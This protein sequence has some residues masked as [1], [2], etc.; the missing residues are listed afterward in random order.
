MGLNEYLAVMP[1]F[2]AA[3]QQFRQQAGGAPLTDMNAALLQQAQQPEFDLMGALEQ[4]QAIP[5]PR[6]GFSENFAQALAGMQFGPP[7]NFG[8][9]LVQGLARGFSGA[10]NRRVASEEEKA[11]TRRAAASELAKARWERVN[12]EKD[13]ARNLLLSAADKEMNR[14]SR[15]DLQAQR[16]EAAWQRLMAQI[17]ASNDRLN[18]SLSARYGAT[19]QDQVEA[20]AMR[21][22]SGQVDGIEKVP[23]AGGMRNAVNAFMVS[24]GLDITPKKYREVMGTLS[25]AESVVESLASFVPKVNKGN[26]TQRAIQ[27]PGKAAAIAFQTDPD[28][29]QYNAEVNG[30][31]AILS[32]A[33]GERGVLTDQDVARAKKLV[34][35]PYDTQK[36]AEGKIRGLREFFKEQKM[37]ANKA[38]STPSSAAAVGGPAKNNDPLGIR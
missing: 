20:W 26:A 7:S 38:W 16:D 27:F 10:T 9:G 32:R 22:H 19:P 4:A 24:N 12:K 37:R 36:V 23:V 8:E 2:F 13:S 6:R 31:L 29:V 14:D 33:A 18:M 5:G 11:E 28:I 30:F 34:P 1:Q 15:G 21:V 3:D 25:S 17:A 35:S